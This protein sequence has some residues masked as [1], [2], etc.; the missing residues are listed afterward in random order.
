MTDPAHSTQPILPGAT[1][2]VMGSGQLGKMFAQAAKQM[3]YHV[4]V[5]SPD[6][7]EAPANQVADWFIQA[8]YEDAEKLAEFADKVSAITL[9]F[10]NIPVS[11][12]AALYKTIPVRPGP[13]VL[14][15]TQDRIREKTT[16]KE[17]GLPVTPF[18]PIHHTPDLESGLA[19]IG[20][21]AVLKTSGFGYDGKGQRK[22]TTLPEAQAA[23]EEL[24]QV[25][26][27]LE[28]FIPFEREVSVIG[29]RNVHGNFQQFGPVENS[30][31]NHILDVSR[32][33]ARVQSAVAQQAIT[34][35]QT[36]MATLEVTGILCVEFFVQPDGKL[37]INETAPRPHNSGHWT[38][39]G[40]VTS[41]FEQQV[42]TVCN[43]PLGSTDIRQPTAMANLLGDL[44]QPD[45]PDWAGMMATYPNAKLHL[46]SKT[47]AKPGRKMGHLTLTAGTADEAVQQLMAAR[48]L[49]S[50]SAPSTQNPETPISIRS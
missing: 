27:V 4:G 48:D 39:E 30:H 41:Q 36:V 8:D 16:L 38:I 23:F 1:L 33:P 50:A 29:A 15:I 26:C 5:Y 14:A 32:V 25:P 22:V 11:A 17:A 7:V 9:E 42:R 28:A 24:G 34:L 49:L 35:T 31:A 19:T 2:G 47:G 40:A 44:W 12:L 3:G 18:V 6:G 45:E 46:Y 13:E 43:L 21:P 37:L 20:T 10:E